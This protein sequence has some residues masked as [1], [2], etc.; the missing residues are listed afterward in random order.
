M[1]ILWGGGQI[2]PTIAEVASKFS[3]GY[4]PE[5]FTH[6]DDKK[7]RLSNF[8]FL[9]LQNHNCEFQKTFSPLCKPFR[10]QSLWREKWVNALL[11]QW[12]SSFH[13]GLKFIL[14]KYSYF[15]Y[16][17]NSWSNSFI[18]NGLRGKRY[19]LKKTQIVFCIE[20]VLQKL[21]WTYN[22]L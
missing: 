4:V 6:W 11:L 12:S 5:F 1:V 20:K 13:I 7:K 21:F 15:L 16:F 18:T 2:L 17:L 19:D 22:D 3:R 14:E 10:K 8:A 9:Y